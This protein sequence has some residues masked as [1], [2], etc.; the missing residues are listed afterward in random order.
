MVSSLSNAALLPWLSHWHSDDSTNKF[1]AKFLQK[2][3]IFLVQK[4]GGGPRSRTSAEDGLQQTWFIDD[5]ATVTQAG[6]Q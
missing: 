5:K 4:V 3:I 1:L 6:R 2:K